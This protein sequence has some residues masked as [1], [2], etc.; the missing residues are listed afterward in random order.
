MAS[1]QSTEQHWIVCP[2]C[3][4]A[5]LATNVRCDSCDAVLDPNATPRDDPG[6][7]EPKHWLLFLG[8]IGFLIA[9]AIWAGVEP[10]GIAAMMFGQSLPILY[11]AVLLYGF[12]RAFLC[13]WKRDFS[14]GIVGCALTILFAL[15]ALPTV[16]DLD[17]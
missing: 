5:N 10:N 9:S 3:H 6:G 1:S 13:F 11:S 7:V 4:I 14:G 2:K 12:A 8:I 17:P 15:A 16:L